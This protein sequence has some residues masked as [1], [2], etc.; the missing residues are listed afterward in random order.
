VIEVDEMNALL[1]GSIPAIHCFKHNRNEMASIKE[2]LWNHEIC[3]CT[4]SSFGHGGGGLGRNA[5]ASDPQEDLC[6][7]VYV[8]GVL[9]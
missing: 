6:W 1:A 4:N 8:S 3:V 2:H 5:T 7:E 9:M